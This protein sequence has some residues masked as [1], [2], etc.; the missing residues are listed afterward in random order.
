MIDHKPQRIGDVALES[1]AR[2]TIKHGLTPDYLSPLE[3][4]PDFG[5][6]F[7]VGDGDLEE[8]GDG[9]AFVAPEG[10]FVGDSDGVDWAKGG[11]Q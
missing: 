2:R 9:V 11:E 6:R 5:V 10:A 4:A 7:E 3:S 1:H 8:W